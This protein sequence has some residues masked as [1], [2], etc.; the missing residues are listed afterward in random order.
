MVY[1]IPDMNTRCSFTDCHSVQR[2]GEFNV[3]LVIDG[4]E[5][6][7]VLP[8]AGSEIRRNR[9]VAEPGRYREYTAAVA[10]IVFAVQIIFQCRVLA[11]VQ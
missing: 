6:P 3:P 10:G 4:D 9:V 7:V 1:A 11:Y 8:T 2:H 5:L